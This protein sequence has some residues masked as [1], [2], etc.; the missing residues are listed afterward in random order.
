[1]KIGISSGCYPGITTEEEILLLQKNDVNATFL[2]A[3]DEWEKVVS[4]AKKMKAAGIEVETIHAD[5]AYINDIWLARE[6]GDAAFV[7]LTNAV[8]YA[9]RLEIPAI[10]VHLSEGEQPPVVSEAGLQR[11]AGLM[12]RAEELGITVCFENQYKLANLA[13]VFE[14]F[15]AA[16]FCWDVGHEACYS[17]GME[18]MPV[19]GKRLGALHLHDNVCEYK[20]DQ[21][22]IPFDGAIDF[23]RVTKQIAK[24]GYE[25]TLM[26]EIGTGGYDIYKSMSAEEYYARA[27]AA[28]RRLEEKVLIHRQ[29][30][31]KK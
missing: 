26:L 17:G 31:Y 5:W 9:A 24:S 30:V 7:Q 19:F 22:R 12:K 29:E 8:E 13:Q 10:I 4:S 23:D 14:C 25:G 6:E 20:K 18:Y 3:W 15:D 16:R 1:M 27:A 2:G 28:A 11:L 21:H